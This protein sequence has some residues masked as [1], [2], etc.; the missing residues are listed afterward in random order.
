MDIAPTPHAQMKI[1]DPRR[2]TISNLA[3]IRRSIRVTTS[4]RVIW[5]W[6]RMNV[7]ARP[8]I[9]Y[10]KNIRRLVGTQIQWWARVT[11]E[12]I[13]SLTVS[14]SQ[15]LMDGAPTRRLRYST[16]GQGFVCYRQPRSF[17]PI[18]STHP[19]IISSEKRS[20][21]FHDNEEIFWNYRIFPTCSRWPT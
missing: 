3:F 19:K 6:G 8:I 17:T 13:R 4:G 12:N 5:T 11:G 15:R 10:A 2:L 1:T 21:L 9:C 16:A 7:W 14:I 20:I 18:N